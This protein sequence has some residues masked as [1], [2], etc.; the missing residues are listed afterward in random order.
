MEENIG[1]LD[2]YIRL[3]SGFTMLGVGIIKKSRCMITLG[4]MKIAEG[5]T[6][7]C[8]ML[9]MLGMNTK[10]NDFLNICNHKKSI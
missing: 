7:F 1:R 8:P 6:H 4:S 2:A 9:Y 10:D 3:T 5:I